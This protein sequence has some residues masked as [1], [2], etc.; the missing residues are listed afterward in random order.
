MATGLREQLEALWPQ[1]SANKQLALD[2]YLEASEIERHW[3]AEG[4]GQTPRMSFDH[5]T[6]AVKFFEALASQREQE[7]SE[8]KKRFNELIALKSKA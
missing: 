3:Q 7:V 5:F 1:E 4:L 2:I 8:L 6:T